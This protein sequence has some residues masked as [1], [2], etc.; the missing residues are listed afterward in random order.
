[1]D[2]SEIAK[3][4]PLMEHVKNCP[5]CLGKYGLILKMDKALSKGTDVPLSGDFESVVWEKIRAAETPVKMLLWNRGI[6]TLAT[7]GALAC[8]VFFVMI[9]K[10]INKQPQTAAVLAAAPAKEIKAATAHRAAVLKKE[11]RTAALPAAAQKDSPA[12]PIT[13]Q[14]PSAA[15]LE[16]AAAIPAKADEDHGVPVNPFRQEKIAAAPYNPAQVTAL[17]PKENNYTAASVSGEL[18]KTYSEK[19]NIKGDVE[20]LGNMIHPL[21]NESV[22][23]KYRVNG[24]GYVIITVYDR[25]GSAVRRLFSGNAQPGQ[26]QLSW[27]GMDDTGHAAATGIYILYIK[28]PSYENKSKIGV[29]K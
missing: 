24:P 21:N 20:V 2:A 25:K 22:I 19:E 15:R 10:N 29:I 1:M 12:A 27:N 3:N 4:T 26:Y 14:A 5:S 6:F 8:A 7:A 17:A 23:V 13:A 9:S 11:T 28:A 16:Q 18:T